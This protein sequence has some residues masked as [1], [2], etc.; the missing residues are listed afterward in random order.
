[1]PLLPAT[2]GIVLERPLQWS[3]CPPQ[4]TERE[5]G[6]RQGPLAGICGG[7]HASHSTGYACSRSEIMSWSVCGPAYQSEV[8]EHKVEVCKVDYAVTID[9]SVG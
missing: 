9:I 2:T 1:M 5:R 4:D 6:Y 7:W 8:G 3:I